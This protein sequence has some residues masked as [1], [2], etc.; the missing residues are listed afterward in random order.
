MSL[1]CMSS[2]ER[3]KFC[4]GNDN[5][6]KFEADK[7]SKFLFNHVLS[8]TEFVSH[9]YRLHPQTDKQGKFAFELTFTLFA[10]APILVLSMLKS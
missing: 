2:I 4:E 5:D 1:V 10:S 8:Q 6:W 9:L 3:C 7:M